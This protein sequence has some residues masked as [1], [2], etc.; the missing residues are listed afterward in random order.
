[1][2]KLSPRWTHLGTVTGAPAGS[3]SE[4]EM[5][6]VGDSRQEGGHG[7][8]DAN[9]PNRTRTVSASGRRVVK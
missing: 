5:S 8:I 2:S 7:N 1:V 3:R 4:V 9:D 6:G